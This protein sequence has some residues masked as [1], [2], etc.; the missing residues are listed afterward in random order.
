MKSL[1]SVLVFSLAL[2]FFS[3]P[4]WAEYRVFLLRI[5]TPEGEV[6]KEF[7]STLDPLQY[8]RFFPLNPGEKISYTSTWMCRERTGGLPFCKNPSEEGPVF[9]AEAAAAANAGAEASAARAPASQPTE[10][11]SPATTK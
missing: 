11:A 4:L 10:T 1:I 3:E 2:C 6:K 5:T 9:D 8:P 7:P